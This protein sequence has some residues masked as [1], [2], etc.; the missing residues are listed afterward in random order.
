MTAVSLTQEA[1]GGLS[2]GVA[3]TVVGYPLDTIKVRMQ[4]QARVGGILSTAAFLVRTEGVLSLYKGMTPPLLSLSILNTVNFTTYAYFHE[5]LQSERGWDP[6]NGIAGAMIGPL[7]A[8]VSTVENLV[9]T[10]MQLD[11]VY[12][13]QYKGSLDCVQ[14]LVK[15]HGFKILYTGHTVNTAREATFLSS[16]FFVYEGL[17]KELIHMGNQDVNKWAVPLAGGLSGAFAW[18]ISFPLDCVRAVIQGSNLSGTRQGTVEV[19]RTL[20]IQKGFI[21]LYSGLTPSIA[22]AFLV[23]GTRFSAYEVALWLLR[24]G[25]DVVD[26]I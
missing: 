6:K 18:G 16:Y 23:S 5:M 15:T 12:K 4:T 3:G 9:K 13:K 19:F 8:T 17:R 10:Q 11:N 21:G 14:K 26:E 22:R 24:G 7:S 2:A 25:R 1:V 20:L